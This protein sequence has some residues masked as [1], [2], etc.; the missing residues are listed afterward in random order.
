METFFRLTTRER[1]LQFLYLLAVTLFLSL[2]ISWIAFRNAHQSASYD[3]LTEKVRQQQQLLRA[4]KQYLPLLDSAYRGIVAYQPQ[5]NAVFVEVDIDDQL[6]EIRRL[7]DSQRDGTRFRSFG[8]I[9]DF[10]KMMYVDKKIIWS[11]QS[12]VNLF[13]KQL[14]DCS[15]G[16][17]PGSGAAVAAPSTP[18]T[19]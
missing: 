3:Y 8:Q 12:N 10:Y 15:V 4:Q 14:D 2:V 18:P 11:K 19:R 1:R 16:L 17:T 13:R 7:S 9:A 5:V 6:N